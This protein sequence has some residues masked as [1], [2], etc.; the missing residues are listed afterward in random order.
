[1]MDEVIIITSTLAILALIVFL[2]V[3]V[4]RRHKGM[5]RHPQPVHVIFK[6][7]HAL[8]TGFEYTLTSQN[9]REKSSGN[10]VFTTETG[11]ETPPQHRVAE[12]DDGK[13]GDT[14]SVTWKL[15]DGSCRTRQT[16]I[17]AS[18]VSPLMVI[19]TKACTVS[20]EQEGASCPASGPSPQALR[21]LFLGLLPIAM[22]FLCCLGTVECV[23]EARGI[24]LGR[25]TLSWPATLGTITK[26]DVGKYLFSTRS[27]SI[28]LKCEYEYIV[29]N[30]KYVNDRVASYSLSENDIH[31]IESRFVAGRQYAVYYDPENPSNSVLIRGSSYAGLVVWFFMVAGSLVMLIVFWKGRKQIWESLK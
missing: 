19:L 31:K 24:Q 14:L 23:K 16:V 11:A 29:G 18:S 27:T 13:Q 10:W 3:Y 4:L 7:P 5:I 21:F 17:S 8:A 12:I 30:K 28:T 22:L 2:V 6:D 1:M 15:L 26:W 25:R 9:W 20:F